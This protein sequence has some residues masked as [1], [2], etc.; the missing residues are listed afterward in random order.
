MPNAGRSSA[1]LARWLRGQGV[2]DEEVPGAVERVRGR[3]ARYPAPVDQLYP[4]L[5][6]AAELAPPHTHRRLL[7]LLHIGTFAVGV[8][9]SAAAELFERM[10]TPSE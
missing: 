7:S 8:G 6:M 4:A 2:A 5:L 9:V 3:V 1:L 10:A